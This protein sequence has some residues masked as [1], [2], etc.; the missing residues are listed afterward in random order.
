MNFIL[1]HATT[2]KQTVLIVPALIGFGFVV[3]KVDEKEKCSG[4]KRVNFKHKSMPVMSPIPIPTKDKGFWQAILLW[5]TESRH[6]K[7]EED[8]HYSLN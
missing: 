4:K 3:N 8:F 6:W 7:I 2:F 1:N 5:L